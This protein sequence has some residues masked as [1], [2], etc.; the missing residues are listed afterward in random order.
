VFFF[1]LFV[2]LLRCFAFCCIVQFY[3]DRLHRTALHP[4]Q[5][6][7][8]TTTVQDVG[9]TSDPYCVFWLG[10]W[11]VGALKTAYLP[12]TL[13]PVWDLTSAPLC[14]PLTHRALEL[15][16]AGKLPMHVEVWDKDPVYDGTCR[17]EGGSGMSAVMYECGWVLTLCAAPWC[18]C[19]CVCVL[20]ISW[21]GRNCICSAQRGTSAS[22]TCSMC[23]CMKAQNPP[24]P[25]ELNSVTRSAVNAPLCGHRRASH[26]QLFFLDF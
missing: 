20:Q 16:R 17:G 25:F 11:P 22:A 26:D 5:H 15:L 4:S 14:F 1:F 24:A 8:T 10:T 21:V 12:K 9:G 19:V 13:M 23:V 6:T 3:A 7:P 2:Y 18:V